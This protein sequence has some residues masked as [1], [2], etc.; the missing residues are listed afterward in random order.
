M[1]RTKRMVLYVFL[2][3]C[4]SGCAAH[5]KTVKPTTVS[6]VTPAVVTE[7]TLQKEPRL[8]EKIDITYSQVTN[9]IDEFLDIEATQTP[10]GK[11]MFLGQSENK[12]VTLEII[13]EKDSVLQASMKL[14]Y[15]EDIIGT[16]ADL[17]QAMLLRF[18]KNT[19]PE[20]GDWSKEV[21]KIIDKFYSM[22]VDIEEEEITLE[23]KLIHVLY[24]KNKTCIVV[25]VKGTSL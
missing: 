17:N 20:H 15:P 10:S 1:V 3:L 14:A 8:T 25:T 16:K 6:T 9:L 22:Q 12:L 7:K 11:P 21:K 18:L 2:G 4:I 24:D 19:A 5:S 23:Q 13:G